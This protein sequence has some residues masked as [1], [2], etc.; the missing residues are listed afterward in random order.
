MVLHWCPLLTLQYKPAPDNTPPVPVSVPAA[1]NS[2]L[3]NPLTSQS[4]PGSLG[5]ASGAAPGP[6]FG[7]ARSQGTNLVPV[8]VGV[9]VGFGGGM[10]LAAL[11]LG[12]AVRRGYV[13]HWR[14]RRFHEMHDAVDPAAVAAA[15]A[16]AGTA[17]D[18][19]GVG[20]GVGADGYQPPHL[21]VPVGTSAG[22]ATSDT[23]KDPGWVAGAARNFKEWAGVSGK[24]SEG[25]EIE[26]GG[27]G[28]G[29]LPALLPAASG[30][31]F[32][33]SVTRWSPGDEP[34]VSGLHTPAKQMVRSRGPP[35][36]L[37]KVK[38]AASGETRPLPT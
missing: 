29:S 37:D 16:A 4:N 36:D 22:D 9:S 5:A 17:V 2:A 14:S 19:A 38:R 27:A 33:D 32:S 20:V 24:K 1:V 7:A 15:A 31:G 30:G 28:S 11:L 3:V 6:P 35:A 34:G 18:S 13:Y 10:L 26:L 8:A 12:F 25:R 21:V 23:N